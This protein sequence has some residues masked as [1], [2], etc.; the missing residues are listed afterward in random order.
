VL[1]AEPGSEPLLGALTLESLAFDV[2][3]VNGRLIPRPWLP[4]FEL[5]PVNCLDE[6]ALA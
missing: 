5:L 3:V 4:L 2:D 6:P 1:F